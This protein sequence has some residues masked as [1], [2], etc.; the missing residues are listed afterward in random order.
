VSEEQNMSG[1]YI[2]QICSLGKGIFLLSVWN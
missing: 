1:K 2:T